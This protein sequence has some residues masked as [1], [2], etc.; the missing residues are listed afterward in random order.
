MDA[1]K[2]EVSGKHYVN[3]SGNLWSKKA[4][5]MEKDMFLLGPAR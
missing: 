5:K 3:G 2:C 1:L 4:V